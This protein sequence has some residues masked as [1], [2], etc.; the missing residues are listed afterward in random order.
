MNRRHFLSSI[1]AAPLLSSQAYAATD[2]EWRV[3]GAD[4]EATR[5]AP[6]DGIN[7]E[8]VKDLKVAWTHHTEDHSVRPQ[9][10]IECTPI[11]VDGTL[12]LLTPRLKVH[13]L[14]AA[15]GEQT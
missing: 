13:A 15:T 11:V 7:K 1:A 9:T 12:Y 6:I 10:T 4:P 2:W 3:Y 14:D 8:N 5:Y